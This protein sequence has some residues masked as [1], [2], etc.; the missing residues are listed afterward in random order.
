MSKRRITVTVSR[1]VEYVDTIE[2]DEDDYLGWNEG[3]TDNDEAMKEYLEAGDDVLDIIGEV[4]E[5]G[6][7]VD[8]GTPDDIIERVT[9]E[10]KA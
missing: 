2:I 8:R 1:T 10:V 5:S 3:H 7:K 9:R 4:V 6:T